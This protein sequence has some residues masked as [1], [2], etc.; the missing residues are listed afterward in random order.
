MVDQINSDQ[1][2]ERPQI[3][4]S[5]KAMAWLL[6]KSCKDRRYGARPLRRA[7]QRHVEDTVADLL[8]RSGEKV[9]HIEVD[10]QDDQLTF[11][12]AKAL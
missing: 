10:V 12:Q 6:D 8:I 7:I 11:S 2:D 4:M 5:E 1:K 3:R 9:S